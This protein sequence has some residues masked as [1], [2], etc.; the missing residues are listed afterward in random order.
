MIEGARNLQ[1]SPALPIELR[2]I[3][4]ET[5]LQWKARVHE[6]AIRSI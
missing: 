6:L 2:P 1:R 4:K 5:G 3:C